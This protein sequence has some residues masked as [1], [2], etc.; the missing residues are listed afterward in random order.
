MRNHKRSDLINY[1]ASQK[2]DVVCP[3]WT[4]Q[5]RRLFR[6]AVIGSCHLQTLRPDAWGKPWSVAY[7]LLTLLSC[8]RRMSHDSGIY[9]SDTAINDS[10]TAFMVNSVYT[11]DHV[12]S[13][14]SAVVQRREALKSR[15]LG[16]GSIVRGDLKSRHQR[17]ARSDRPEGN[18]PTCEIRCIN[19]N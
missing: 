5:A 12:R 17:W 18:H 6:P 15:I 2:C 10:Y 1:S 3:R 11:S 4:G 14:Q 16:P 7:L 9:L 19:D 8:A 13:A